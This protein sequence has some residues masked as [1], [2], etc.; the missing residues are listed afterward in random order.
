MNTL[1][2]V[3]PEV[4]IEALPIRDKGGTIVITSLAV[5]FQL[6]GTAG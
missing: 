2:I 1:P 5:R 6:D 3:T 4:T